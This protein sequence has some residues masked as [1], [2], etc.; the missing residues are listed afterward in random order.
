MIRNVY[1]IRVYTDPR[2]TCNTRV[3][4]YVYALTF[5]GG[6]AYSERYRV[7]ALYALVR[8]QQ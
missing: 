6:L 1:A 2:L 5:T 8:A 3:L 4:V 7:L